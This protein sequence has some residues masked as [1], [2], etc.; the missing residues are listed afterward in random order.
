MF[1]RKKS[2]LQG[3]ISKI[4]KDLLKIYYIELFHF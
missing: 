4:P 1:F 2:S 3:D